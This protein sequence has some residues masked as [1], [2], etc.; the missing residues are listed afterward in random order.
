VV[1]D[2]PREIGQQLARSDWK[3]SVTQVLQEKLHIPLMEARQSIRASLADTEAA[4]VLAV[5]VGAPLLS[6]D[7]VVYTDDGTPVD[8][9]QTHYRS[10]I[11]SFT[12]HQ[13][14]DHPEASW[15][16]DGR[17]KEP[18]RSLAKKRNGGS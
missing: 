18:Q 15:A 4:R 11:F 5:R 3:G 10:D 7:R 9:V 6:V 12:V 2:L 8:R 17:R 14:R 13:R 16:F 1:N